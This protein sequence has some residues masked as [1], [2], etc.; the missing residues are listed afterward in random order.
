[1]AARASDTGVGSVIVIDLARVGTGSGLGRALI[2][3]VRDAV[4]GVTLVAGGGE[5]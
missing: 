4:P 2:A 1:M 5:P 3:R